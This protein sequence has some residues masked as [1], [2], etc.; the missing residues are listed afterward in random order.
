MS[1]SKP[2]IQYNTTKEITHM[3]P[4]KR[5]TQQEVTFS[6]AP[7][8]FPEGFEKIFLIIYV[9]ITPYI[10]GILFMAFYISWGNIKLFL[11]IYEKSIFVSTWAIGYEIL[12]VIT[13]LFIFKKSLLFTKESNKDKSKNSFRRP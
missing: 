11:S 3:K 10:V 1:N 9:I 6:D 5:F 8:F 2:N 4:L 7:L 12:A 13:L